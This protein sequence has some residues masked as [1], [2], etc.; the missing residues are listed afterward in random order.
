MQ[1]PETSTGLE[2]TATRAI[3]GDR[4]ALRAVLAAVQDDVYAIAL[5]M[6]G[7]PPAAEDAAQEILVQVMTHLA[8]W[9]GEA[10]LR[11]WVYRIAVRH[12]ARAKSTRLEELVSFERLDELVEAGSYAAPA[13]GFNEAELQVLERE[14]RLVCT[15][16]MLLCLDRDLRIAWTLSELFELDSDRA[17][18]VLEIAPAT[19]RKRLQRAREK[20]ADW[21]SASCGLVD[22]K[23]GCNCRRQIP[24]AMGIGVVDPK[25]LRFAPHPTRIRE[26]PRSHRLP[27][28]AEEAER[29]NVCAH[30]LCEHPD[31][32]APETLVRKIRELIAAPTLQTFD[33]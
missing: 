9:R 16:G 3:S 10:A 22:P 4:E 31:Y 25:A 8:Q 26:V 1:M 7:E 24:V 28:L 27:L 14:L 5:R 32:A 21:M 12:V 2:A 33:T 29:L 18:D 20:L 19:F 11:T 17:A 13:A 15:E 23:N 30:V 6:L